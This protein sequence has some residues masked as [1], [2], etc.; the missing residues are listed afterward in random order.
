MGLKMEMRAQMRTM[1]GFGDY[2]VRRIASN[3]DQTV[4]LVSGGVSGGTQRQIA[5]DDGPDALSRERHDAKPNRTAHSAQLSVASFL[6]RELQHR[7]FGTSL[8]DRDPTGTGHAS[9]LILIVYY[10]TSTQTL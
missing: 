8:K 6:Q 2:V 3:A 1:N 5:Q 4:T 7:A 10:N 9:L